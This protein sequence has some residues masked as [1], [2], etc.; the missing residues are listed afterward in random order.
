MFW[1]I[2]ENLKNEIGFERL[3][4]AI[5]LRSLPFEIIK[6]IPFSHDFVSEPH[7]TE[8]AVIVSGST[9]LSKIAME[10]GWKPGA[11]LNDNFDFSVWKEAYKG[12]LLNEDGT[13]EEFGK[14]DP[15]EP[16]FV[17][18]CSDHKTFAGF[19]IEP[20]K[21]QAWQE[22]IF[23]ISDGYATLTPETLV[24]SATPKL[25]YEEYRFFVIDGQVITGSLY[26]AG[27]HLRYSQDC[28]EEARAF[29]ES[30]A[31]V[32][33]PDRAFVIDIAT[34]PNGPKIIEINCLTSSG[35]YEADVDCLVGALEKSFG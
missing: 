25:I 4:Q 29:A 16:I 30:A 11:F 21:L 17:R 27:D 24:L 9:A 33:Q 7:I 8:D 31:Q 3:L 1:V 15:K 10:R 22:Q 32:W 5:N 34:T 23:G 2:Q 35:F 19:I 26:K 20:D 28:D 14:L 18:P 6:I 13:I 12:L